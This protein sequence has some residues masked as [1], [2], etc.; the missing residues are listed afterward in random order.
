M[1]SFLSTHLQNNLSSS[2]ADGK[3]EGVKQTASSK[4]PKSREQ[5]NKIAKDFESILVFQMLKSMRS[6]VPKSELLGGYR[7]EMF[8]SMFDQELAN[9]ISKGEG[10]GLSDMLYKQLV[11]MEERRIPGSQKIHSPEN[12]KDLNTPLQ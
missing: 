12:R 3:F 4:E 8:E 2:V 5:L 6:T 9:E 1:D 7:S 11:A 10:I